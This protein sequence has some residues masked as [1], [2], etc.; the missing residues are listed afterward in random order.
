MFVRLSHGSQQRERS[1]AGDKRTAQSP[2]CQAVE[3]DR[4]LALSSA[5][6][7]ACTRAT[8]S[9]VQCFPF[10]RNPEEWQPVTASLK[11]PHSELGDSESQITG[12]WD[13]V[14]HKAW[15]FA[16]SADKQLSW[17]AASAT[18]RPGAKLDLPGGSPA[19]STSHR[20]RVQSPC[21]GEVWPFPLLTLLYKTFEAKSQLGAGSHCSERSVT[22]PPYS[23]EWETEPGALSLEFD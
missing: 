11:T 21:V 16:W 5:E 13:A 22:D 18:T 4:G 19:A 9:S 3:E 6:S 23:G 14:S 2:S 20:K 17:L 7:Y 1:N 8:H 12:S 15:D 10:Y